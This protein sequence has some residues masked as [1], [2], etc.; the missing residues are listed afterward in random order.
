MCVGAVDSLRIGFLNTQEVIHYIPLP[1]Q[2]VIPEYL[3]TYRSFL[4]LC[5]VFP[6]KIFE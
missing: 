1:I 5:C 2:H 6:K 4:D 3:T